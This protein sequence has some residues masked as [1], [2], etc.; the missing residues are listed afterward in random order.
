MKCLFKPN[1]TLVA[2]DY[3]T[4]CDVQCLNLTSDLSALDSALFPRLYGS[5]IKFLN[6]KFFKI[7]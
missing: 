6:F 2:V 3:E 5:D 1:V 4:L 7:F